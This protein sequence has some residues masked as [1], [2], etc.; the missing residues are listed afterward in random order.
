MTQVHPLI[1]CGGTGSRLWPLSRAESPKQFQKVGGPESLT[2]FQTAVQRHMGA[3][4]HRPC[5]VTGQMHRATAAEQLAEMQVDGRMICEPMGRN[6]GPAV[7]AAA[8][9]LVDEDPDAIMIVIPADHVIHGPLNDAVAWAIPAVQ[10]GH[11]VTFGVAPRY[12]ETG[13]GYITDDGAMGDY[14]GVRR[15]GRFVEKP[16]K[17]EAQ[18][19][20]DSRAAYWASGLSM[21]RAE[22][23]IEEYRRFD[24]E[25]VA[26]V[27]YAVSEGRHSDGALF[28]H[29]KLLVSQTRRF[30]CG[31][32]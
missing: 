8:L 22:T 17:E 23:L 28:L 6:T 19:L 7:L 2:F 21:F 26:D 16:P 11:I 25:S 32:A 1:I 15:I 31:K 18:R 9:A 3:L 29:C 24:P 14:D 12:A 27:A 4:Y 5:I 20:I 10:D 30:E 13:F